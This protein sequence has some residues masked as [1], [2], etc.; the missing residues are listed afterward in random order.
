MKQGS[1]ILGVDDAAF[2]FDDDSTEL[3]GVVYRGT[4]FIEDVGV[5]EV[6]VDG[7]D[8]TAE[9]LRLHEE[10][11]NPGQVAAVLMD[12]ISLA[13]FNLVDI[14]ELS[15]RLDKPVIAVTS[16]RP[17]REDFRETME[18]TDNRDGR[19]EEF[20][21][22]E[23]VELKDGSCFIQFSGVSQ[24]EAEEIVRSSTIHGLTPEPVRVAHMIGR[25]L[26]D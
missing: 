24:D 7:E 26:R 2:S 23:E 25:A 22:A 1:R 21:E 18:K 14:H 20:R 10:M 5:A 13:G 11:K 16:N 3:L 8:A 6:T 19:F 12:G 17:D 15:D 9:V 4:E